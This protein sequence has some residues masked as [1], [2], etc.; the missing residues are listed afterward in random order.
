[1]DFKT[2]TKQDF[3]AYLNTPFTVH[4]NDATEVTLT[5]VKTEEK[6]NYP[7]YSFTL[8]FKGPVEPTFEGDT[9]KFDHSEMGSGNIFIKPYRR[10]TKSVLYDVQFTRMLDDDDDDY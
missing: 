6:T 8:I 5:L 2:I 9:Y 1:L 3:D 10:K 4:I 7:V